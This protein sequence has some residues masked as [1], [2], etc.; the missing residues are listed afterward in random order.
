MK[1]LLFSVKAVISCCLPI[2][3]CMEF[4]SNACSEYSD[5][6]SCISVAALIVEKVKH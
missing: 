2:C 3:S 4:Q 5:L 1:L 6:T